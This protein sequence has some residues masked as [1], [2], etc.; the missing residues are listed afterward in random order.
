M[1]H[2]S[3]IPEIFLEKLKD[4]LTYLFKTEKQID[5]SF[6][7]IPPLFQTDGSIVPAYHHVYTK[8]NKEPLIPQQ[9]PEWEMTHSNEF[10]EF[11]ICFRAFQIYYLRPIKNKLFHLIGET[12]TMSI[13]RNKPLEHIIVQ[14][15]FIT[16][17][18]QDL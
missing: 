8:H 18:E 9:K 10:L 5:I 14:K 4:I 6:E 1:N 15:P 11:F 12:K 3:Q 16:L 13:W 7:T 2:V 17:E